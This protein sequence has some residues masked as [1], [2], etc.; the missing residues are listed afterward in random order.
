M[1]AQTIPSMRT[2]GSWANSLVLMIFV[3]IVS[4]T[5]AP[6]VMEPANSMHVAINM[7]CFIV[8][9]REDADVAKKFTTSLAP[10]SIS[11]LTSEVGGGIIPMF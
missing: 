7:A 1:T 10:V 3:R 4:D 5:R 2:E 8:R 9:D 6:T 11:M